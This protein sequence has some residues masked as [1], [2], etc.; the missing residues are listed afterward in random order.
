MNK[1]HSREEFDR[2]CDAIIVDYPQ[3]A[4]RATCASQNAQL[5]LVEVEGMS[6]EDAENDMS[7]LFVEYFAASM[8][9]FAEEVA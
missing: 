1:Q 5:S 4:D 9:G 8:A 7:D 2:R 3:V 6:Q